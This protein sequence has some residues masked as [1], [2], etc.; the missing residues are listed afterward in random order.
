M[1]VKKSKV[2]WWRGLPT[3]KKIIHPMNLT[4]FRFCASPFIFIDLWM[5]EAT[6]ALVLFL[7]ATL[8]DLAD[9]WIARRYGLASELGKVRDSNADK[10][11]HWPQFLF[12]L[13]WPRPDLPH[14]FLYREIPMKY[15]II[16]SLL[17][18]VAYSLIEALLAAS[19]TSALEE[20]RRDGDNGAKWV[21]K[22]KTWAQS[23][24]VLCY[25]AG[26]MFALEIVCR[27]WVPKLFVT[28]AQLALVPAGILGFLSLR[29]R[30]HLNKL[31]MVVLKRAREV[32]L[33]L[34]PAKENH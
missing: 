21:G 3:Y 10:F 23:I 30:I 4:L 31:P 9:G 7:I 32:Y 13:A 14:Y 8:T 11:L 18:F 28:M 16:V 5:G 27:P 34:H 24:C 22:Y 26:M 25:I 2:Y 6:N 19:R 15:W 20:C 33:R 29:S 17:F 12:F 1:K